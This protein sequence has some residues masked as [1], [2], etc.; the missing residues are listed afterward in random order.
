MYIFPKISFRLWKH[1]LFHVLLFFLFS[2]RWKFDPFHCFGKWFCL[3]TSWFDLIW[4]SVK[5]LPDGV[6]GRSSRGSGTDLLW[7]WSGLAEKDSLCYLYF[8][9]SL[10]RRQSH[11]WTKLFCNLP[12]G[13]WGAFLNVSGWNFEWVFLSFLLPSSKT[14]STIQTLT[15][16]VL[17]FLRC[18][19]HWHSFPAG[20]HL[21]TCKS[22][23]SEFM[24]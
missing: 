10:S 1:I 20:D 16:A 6:V 17:Q 9:S 11:M 5:Y 8:R 23:Q 3:A 21:V 7:N 19:P 12:A 13:I 24:E 14:F 15:G 4:R 18:F 22:T 2:W